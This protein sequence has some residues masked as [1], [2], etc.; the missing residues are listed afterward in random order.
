MG[1]RPS[2]KSLRRE[3]GACL[4]VSLPLAMNLPLETACNLNLSERTEGPPGGFQSSHPISRYESGIVLPGSVATSRVWLFQ[5]KLLT[6][7]IRNSVS[8]QHQPH[9]ERSIACDNLK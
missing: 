1:V 7:K 3:R 8:Q 5:L 2:G 9:F 4:G 6:L